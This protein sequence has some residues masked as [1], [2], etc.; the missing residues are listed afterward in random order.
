M[1]EKN[2]L[3]SAKR[4]GARYGRTVKHRLAKIEKEQRKRHKCPYCAKSAVRRVFAG[5][6]HCK[7]CGAKFT[8]RAYTVTKQSLTLKKEKIEEITEKIKPKEEPIE[9]VEA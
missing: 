4:F 1:A 3:G 2:K 7:S 5:V 6:W 9:E 8:S